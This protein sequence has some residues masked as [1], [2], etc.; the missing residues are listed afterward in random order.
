MPTSS[1]TINPGSRW[2]SPEGE[3]EV[4]GVKE[5]N[6]E[7]YVL[8][9]GTDMRDWDESTGFPCQLVPAQTLLQ[10]WTREDHRWSADT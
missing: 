3:W 2:R 6:G 7:I 9:E 10:E 1:P 8:L 5:I 4:A